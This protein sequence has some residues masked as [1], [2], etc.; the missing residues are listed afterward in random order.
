LRPKVEVGEDGSIVAAEGES[1][2]APVCVVEGHDD[3]IRVD[4]EGLAD[5]K[6]SDFVVIGIGS[7]GYFG[8]A[9]GVDVG[10]ES[11]SVHGGLR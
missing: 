8:D 6:P 11:A 7:L 1:S 3:A 10:E 9:A 5:G 2:V 4:I